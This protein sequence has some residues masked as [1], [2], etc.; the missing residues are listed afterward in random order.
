MSITDLASKIK[1]KAYELVNRNDFLR[2]SLISMQANYSKRRYAVLASGHGSKFRFDGNNPDKP[3]F[4]LLTIEEA[5]AECYIWQGDACTIGG[6]AA[7]Y[8]AITKKT[9]YDV[10]NLP[11]FKDIVEKTKSRTLD[12]YKSLHAN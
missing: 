7:I 5:V 3:T 6:A 9:R 2:D 4:P 8:D 1:G 10:H 11:Q 12:L